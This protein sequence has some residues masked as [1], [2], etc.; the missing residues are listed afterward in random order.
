[1]NR[2]HEKTDT[3]A[4]SAMPILPAVETR[5]LKQL[6]ATHRARARAAMRWRPRFLKAL[7]MSCSLTL[8][9]RAAKVCYNTVRAH[10]RND[11]EFAAQLKEAEEEGAQ[12]LHAVC[13]QAALQGELQPVYWQGQIVGHIKKY[14]S[15]LRIEMLRAHMPHLF[16]TPGSH[17]PVIRS[18]NNNKGMIMTPERQDELIRLRREALEAMKLPEFR[19]APNG[20]S[21]DSGNSPTLDR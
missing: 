20:A 12:L 10:E 13:F 1:M 11:P 5:Y 9:L 14:D 7:A 16:K 18:D 8:A 4:P 15:R 3:N 21:V 17:A 6:K 2:S 19:D